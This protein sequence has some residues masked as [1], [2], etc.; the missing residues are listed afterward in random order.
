[1]GTILHTLKSCLCFKNKNKVNNGK[2]INEEIFSDINFDNIPDD[3][4][5]CSKC[6]QIPEILNIFSDNNKIQYICKKCGLKEKDLKEY[7]QEVSKSAFTYLKLCDN[8]CEYKIDK[9]SILQ[10]CPICKKNL[11]TNCIRKYDSDKK[12]HLKE[13]LNSVIPINKKSDYCAQ[14]YTYKNNYFCF[15]CKKNIC[16]IC[17]KDVHKEHDYEKI[18]YSDIQIYVDIIIEKN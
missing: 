5:Y 16:V 2:K 1:M 17:S 3:E 11:C 9:K 14:H 8:L 13:H 15:D 6:D 7:F 4:F 12:G 10:Y 18:N